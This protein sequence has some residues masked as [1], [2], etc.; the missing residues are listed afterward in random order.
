MVHRYLTPGAILESTNTWLADQTF[1]DNIALTFGTGG[2]VDVEYNGT[3]FLINTRVVGTGN[4]VFGAG[5]AG[6]TAPTGITLRSPNIA[7]GGAG[8]VAGADLTVIP[9]LGTG[10]GDAG[11][12][13][14][15]LPVVA[16]SGDNIQTLVTAMT[17]DMVASTSAPTILWPTG[18][19]L[20]FGGGDVTI[21][22][23][24]NK[25]TVAGGT[26]NLA[27]NLVFDSGL[28]IVMPAN[29][30]E[31]FQLTNGTNGYLKVNTPLT[32]NGTAAHD[33]R[34]P[35]PT[36][37]SAST[38]N[39]HN[40]QMLGYTLTL[41]DGTNVT[42]PID[43]LNLRL[44]AATI[45]DSTSVTVTEAS[46]FH[47]AAPLQAGSVTITRKLAASFG[48]AVRLEN[49]IFAESSP[50]E[51]T[52]GEQLESAGAGAVV[53]W[54]T[55]GSR[56]KYKTVGAEVTDTASA[57][58]TVVATPVFN[59][60]YPKP[61]YT[62]V[63][64]VHVEPDENGGLVEKTVM[65][66]TLVGERKLSTGDYNTNYVGVMA[67]DAPW[68]MH[69]DGNMLNPTNTFGYTVLAIK[70]LEARLTALE[71]V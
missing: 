39:W 17:L 45:T 5:E 59:F 6:T 34:V 52:A 11:T 31:A 30:N 15:Q 55:A 27:G 33:F 14:I 57:L 24:S 18:T 63:E 58:A 8:N 3:D 16:A 64:E 23:A 53:I 51:G 12:L 28:D 41:T 54:A 13:I 69:H 44:T 60:K 4:V 26:L 37:A 21:T 36:I 43:G 40:S 9:G 67:E 65:V 25:V 1:L 50:T 66:P 49:S 38:A 35:A 32:S 62:N 7:T 68:A 48:G 61:R 46:T 20:D 42:T 2:D 22:H 19:I 71:A 70:E 47:T 56:R 10:T 29:T